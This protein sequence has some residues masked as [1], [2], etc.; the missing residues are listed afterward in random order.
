MRTLDEVARKVNSLKDAARDRDQRQRDVHDVRSGDIDTVI[1]GSMPDAWPRPVVANM[2]DT[3]ARDTSEVMGQMPSINCTNSLQT[4]DRSKKFSSKRTKVANHYTLVSGLQAGQQVKLCDQYLSFGMGVYSVEPDF[5]RK[6]PVIR[7]ENPMGA[8]PEFDMFHRLKSY[9]R[10]WREEAIY[11]VAKYPQLMRV[12][13][14]TDS[15]GYMQDEGWAEREIEVC[16]YMDDEVIYMY[17]PAHSNTLIDVMPNPMG[18]LTIS[19]AVRP[20]YDGEIRGAYDDA[21]WVYL[22]KSRMAMLGLEATE[23]AVR[24]PLAIPRDVQR[25]VFGSDS[26]IRTD[27]PE[28]I[29]YVGID[30]PQFA[31]QEEQLLERELRLSTRSPQAR[32]GNID[33]SIITGKGVEALMGGFDTVVTTGQQVIGQALKKA[34]EFA[35]EMDEKLWPNEKKTI[36][37][38]VQGAPFEETYIPSKDINGNY[39]VDVT[40]GFAAGQDPARAIVALLQLRGDNLVSR[41]FVQRQLPM[42][43]DVVQMQTQIDNEQFEDALK[44]GIQGAMQAIPQMALQGMDPMDP[45]MK[46]AEVIKLREGG[47]PVHEAILQAFKPKEAPQGPLGGP[48]GGAGPT[49]QPGPGGA[50][51]APSGAAQGGGRDMMQLL[52]SLKG[53]GQ[54]SMGVRTRR[55]QPI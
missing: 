17:L 12:L 50:P 38:V 49:G 28:K 7:I 23:K 41:D 36:R 39:P 30:M 53:G 48:E 37:G 5:D 27:S 16:K 26:V 9:S 10:I 33:A 35:F 3:T 22:A 47:K 43:I 14:K 6:T 25:M 42:E 31:A 32:S 24:A 44:A 51:M 46:M 19:V 2:I 15:R 54:A 11:L 29:K 52:A 45:L 40:Y 55:E 34:L 1:P 4:S 20:S 18:K 8:Y 13:K 21:I